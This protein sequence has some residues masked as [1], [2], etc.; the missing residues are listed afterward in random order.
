MVESQGKQVSDK[1]LAVSG[2]EVILLVLLVVFGMGLCVWVERGFTW[3]YPE[4]AQPVFL[5][6]LGIEAKQEELTRLESLQKA[7]ATQLDAIELDQLKQTATII[8]LEAQYPDIA[9]PNQKAISAEAQRSYEAAKTQKLAQDA[10]TTLLNGRIVRLKSDAKVVSEELEPA[11]RFAAEELQRAKTRYL[12]AKLTISFL[13]PLIVV[14]VAL[15]VL[16]SFLKRVAQRAMWTNQGVLPFLLV[17]CA[18]LILLAY[19]ALEVAGAVFI[20]IILFLILLWKIDWSM[21]ANRKAE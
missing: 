14:M 16:R 3:L 8:S 21:R 1:Q 7:A 13:V 15:T 12:L 11:K 2:A 20:A 19:Q 9:K 5:K 10:L 18:L 6:P 4:P 17:A